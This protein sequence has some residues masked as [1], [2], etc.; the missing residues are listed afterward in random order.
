M[1][2]IIKEKLKTY[3][4][5]E[6]F[7]E[8][9][10]NTVELDSSNGTIKVSV[11][12]P[13]VADFIKEYY[14]EYIEKAKYEANIDN[15]IE[16]VSSSGKDKPSNTMNLSGAGKSKNFTKL[17]LNEDYTFENFVVGPSNELAFAT[18]KAVAE[19]PG[20]LYNPLYIY[21]DTGLGKTHLLHAVAHSFCRIFPDKKILLISAEKF[22]FDYVS[23]VKSNNFLP[24]R[25]KYREEI[26]KLQ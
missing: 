5:E 26:E 11:S 9:F 4:P 17:S 24:F 22:F 18:C 13:E 14:W 25:E 23:A 1:W 2:N 7:K 16:F 8:W 15:P 21:G 10:E 12:D 3:I 6:S 19:N 20:V